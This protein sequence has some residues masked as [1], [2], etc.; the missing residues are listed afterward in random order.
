MLIFK[1]PSCTLFFLQHRMK[2]IVSIYDVIYNVMF[3][4]QN[5]IP[6]MI[7]RR[8][9]IHAQAHLP[10]VWFYHYMNVKIIVIIIIIAD[11][12]SSNNNNR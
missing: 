5:L 9:V 12:N 6:E 7:I 1:A 8:T 10:R 2:N 4:H 3:S 11:H